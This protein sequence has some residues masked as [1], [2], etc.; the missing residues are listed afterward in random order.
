MVIQTADG[1]I[2]D[3]SHDHASDDINLLIKLQDDNV[4]SF[5]Q[6]LKDYVFYILPKSQSVGDDLYQQLSRNDQVIKKIFWVEKYIDFADKNKTRLIGIST[7]ITDIQTR[8]YRTFIKKLRMDSRVRSLYNAELSATQQ[9][10]YNQLKIA[11][12]SKVRI[13]YKEEELI[14]ISR[15]DDSQEIA[16]FKIMHIR[17]NGK[18]NEIKLNVRLDN[19]EPIIFNALSDQSFISYLNENKPN[20]II[21]SRSTFI[22]GSSRPSKRSRLVHSRLIRSLSVK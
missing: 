9:F 5:K 22:T 6:K 14:S 12:T 20:I 3:V 16:P 11:L 19:Q 8:N 13:E 15:I 4:V 21:I 10:I 7:N 1:W 18:D 17:V 2:L